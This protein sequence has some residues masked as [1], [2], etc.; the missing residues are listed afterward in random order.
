MNRNVILNTATAVST[1]A[2]LALLSGTAAGQSYGQQQ[3]VPA[4]AQQQAP[5]NVDQKTVETFASA[6][7]AVQ[8]IQA[9]YKARIE[10]AREPE[11]ATTLQREAQTEMVEAVKEKGLSVQRY[12]QYAQLMQANPGFRKQVE[13]A[14]DEQ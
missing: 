11:V 14:M 6:L 4:T 12:N 1:L 10:Q 2:A 3:G 7:A 8:E 13:R 5:A 9:E